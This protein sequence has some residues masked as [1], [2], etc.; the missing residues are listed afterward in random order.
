MLIDF[1]FSNWKSFRDETSFSM[2][3]GLEKQHKERVACISKYDLKLLPISSIYGGNASGKSNF[4]KALEFCKS[5]ICGDDFKPK[6]LIPVSGFRTAK[7]NDE[8]ENL[9][10]CFSFTILADNNIV[11]EY[12]FS[13]TREEVLEESLVKCGEKQSDDV[14]VFQR[15]QD[16]VEFDSALPAKEKERLGYIKKGTHGNQLFLTNAISQKVENDDF[17]A[18][19]HWFQ[20]NLVILTPESAVSLKHLSDV[21]WDKICSVLSQLGTGI[22]RLVKTN[23]PLEDLALLSP[24]GFLDFVKEQLTKDSMS[25]FSLGENIYIWMDND[26]IKATRIEF[27]HESENGNTTKFSLNEQSDGTQRAIDLL[28]AFFDITSKE[29][30]RVFV[31]DEID[32]SMHTFMIQALVQA[33]LASCDENSRAQ[34]VFTTHNVMLMDQDIFRRD[35]I[36][37]TER[38]CDGQSNLRSFAEFKDVRKDKKLRKSYLQGRMGGIPNISLH[39][40]F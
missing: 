23:I 9:P 1:S 37:V 15:N 25:S 16:N 24:P 35:E 13:I 27:E 26:E 8:K 28:P 32:R 36:W 11:Y 31:I 14:V 20:Q 29:S 5:F 19:Y 4:V 3:A 21:K 40:S 30:R 18:V 39:G 6:K 10:S 38:Q 34:L 17:H 33:Y 12:A 2:Q 7:K 22:K